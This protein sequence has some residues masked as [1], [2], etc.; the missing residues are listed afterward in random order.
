MDV[1]ALAR[2]LPSA[3]EHARRF[4]VERRDRFEK[5]I[6]AKLD[7]EVKVRD[8]L[9]ARRLHQ[10][11][12]KLERSAQPEARKMRRKERESHNHVLDDGDEVPVLFAGRQHGSISLLVL[13]AHDAPGDDEDPLALKPHHAQFHG[14]APPPDGLLGES[15]SDVV[16]RRIFGQSHPPRWVILLTAGQVLLIV[17][18]KWTHNRRRP[19]ARSPPEAPH[20]TSHVACGSWPVVVQGEAVN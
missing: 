18:G 15:W 17:R 7:E 1:E 4:I 9:L 6:D 8:Q 14:E 10:L 5:V 12:L 19:G 2:R 3:V 13:G 16:T 20:R 11:E